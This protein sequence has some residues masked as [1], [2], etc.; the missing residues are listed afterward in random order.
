MPNTITNRQMVFFLAVAI[1]PLT[2]ITLPKDMATGAGHGAWL[3]LLLVSIVFAFMAVI[4]V[5]LN[6]MYEGQVLFDYSRKIMGPAAPYILGIFYVLYFTLVSTYLC[7]G[8]TTILKTGILPRTPEWF[9]LLIAM[10]VYG[11]IAYRGIT[12]IAR[13]AEIVGFIFFSVALIVT[14]SMLFEGKTNNMLP[15]FEASKADKYIMSAKDSINSFLGIEIL[16]VIPFTQK[17]KK[18]SK[19]AFYTMIGIGLFYII[20]VLGCYAMLG[21]EEIKYHNYPLIDAIRLVEY[22][23]IEFLQRVDIIYDTIGFMHVILA[24]SI[25]YL[26]IVEYLCKLFKKTKRAI[27]VTGVGLLLFILSNLVLHMPSSNKLFL[28]IIIYSGIMASFIIPLTL[29]TF[30]KVKRNAKKNN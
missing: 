12:N 13:L 23:K 25:V 19:A 21:L 7:S 4:I 20:D 26:A 2:I 28:S 24:K 10:P 29:Y 1:T 22:R 8:F 9:T 16:T 30:A 27:I 14:I 18:A 17:N 6:M 5:K 15:L 3:V 11:L